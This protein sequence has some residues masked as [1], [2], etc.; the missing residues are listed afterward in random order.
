M[1]SRHKITL[2]FFLLIVLFFG[3]GLL[4]STFRTH[5]IGQIKPIETGTTQYPS[6]LVTAGICTPWK[7]VNTNAFG[8][9]S[10]FDS[11][12]RP[13]TPSSETPFQSEEGFEVLVFKGQL[14]LGMEADNIFGARLW[15]TRNGV[16]APQTQLDWEEVAAD[17]AGCPF[18]ICDTAQ[19][20]HVDSLAEF[21]GW[22]YVSLANRSGSPQGTLVFRSPSGDPDTWEDAL[23]KI[24]PG[25]SKSQNE[26]FKDMQVFDGHLCGGTWNEVDGAE[27]WCTTDGFNWQQKNL[28]GFG[29]VDN[30]VIWSGH[31]FKGQLYFG[32]QNTSQDGETTHGRLY[33]TDSLDQDQPAWEEVFRSTP[34]ISWGNIL[35]D[36]NGYLYISTP[37][38]EGMRVYRSSSGDANTW[39][40][41]SLPG[42]ENDPTNW[43][44]LADGATVYQGALYAGVVNGQHTFNLWRTTGDHSEDSQIVSWEQIP[45]TEILDPYNIYAQLIAFNERLYAWTSN[46]VHGQQVWQTFCGEIPEGQVSDAP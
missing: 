24:G 38:P 22:I 2:V 8:L 29:E 25:F 4:W 36:L 26:N 45:T 12:N 9:P 27:V 39:E 32:V 43:S 34:G 31:V 5:P 20:D 40:I 11:S 19:A 42:F 17:Q 1:S 23:A 18:G 41:T 15:R 35:G 28:S 30:I 44:V 21:Q 13:I 33:R 14:Y 7:Q 3:M 37:S 10:E 46:P 6:P 16:T